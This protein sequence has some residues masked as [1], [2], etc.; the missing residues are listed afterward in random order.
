MSDTDDL[1]ARQPD[2]PQP[3]RISLRCTAFSRTRLTGQLEFEDH[4]RDQVEYS[5]TQA[6][7]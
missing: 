3:A 5:V 1:T 2:G 6:D 4:T 7:L